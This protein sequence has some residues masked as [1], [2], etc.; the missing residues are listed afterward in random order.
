M[1]LGFSSLFL[2]ERKEDLNAIM[3]DIFKFLVRMIN[4]LATIRLRTEKQIEEEDDEDQDFEETD[5]WMEGK[6]KIRTHM[7]KVDAAVFF[8][9]SFKHLGEKEPTVFAELRTLLTP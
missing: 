2:I 8:E 7:D 9:T 1:I 5:C 6:D 4:K 3:P